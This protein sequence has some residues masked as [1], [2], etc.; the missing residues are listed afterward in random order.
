MPVPHSSQTPRGTEQERDQSSENGVP[1]GLLRWGQAVAYAVGANPTG[2]S[3]LIR[4]LHVAARP[5]NSEPGDLSSSK[6]HPAPPPPRCDYDLEGN[7]V[8]ALGS[9]GVGKPL[10][11]NMNFPI[12]LWRIK[13]QYLHISLQVKAYTLCELSFLITRIEIRA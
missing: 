5:T 6:N 9:E 2:T 13:R 8:A 7:D 12:H 3:F 4:L 1:L 11:V 10:P